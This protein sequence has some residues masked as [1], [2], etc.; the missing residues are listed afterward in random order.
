MK[1]TGWLILGLLVI[2]S[3]KSKSKTEEKK[4]I[5]VVSIIND[6]VKKIDTS[7]YSIIKIVSTDSL[8]SDTS[9]IPRENFRAEAKEFLETPDLS[10]KKKAKKFIE[11]PAVMDQLLNRVIVSYVP[12]KPDEEEFKKIELLATPQ[13]GESQVNNIIITR[14]ISNRDSVLQ[15]KMLWQVD[16]SFQIVTISQK[17][18]KPQITTTT[19]LIWNEG[20][21]Q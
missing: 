21:D 11:E 13:A 16:K 19:R 4:Y 12:V 14:E 1:K 8:H 20:P 18:G 2:V 6:Q 10:D 17:P 3:C 15:K 5:S 9:Y 7:M